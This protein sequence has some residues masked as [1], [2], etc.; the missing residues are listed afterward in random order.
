MLL[1]KNQ[2][3]EKELSI[4]LDSYEFK[5]PCMKSYLI[6]IFY[7]MVDLN[8][9]LANPFKEN[10]NKNISELISKNSIDRNDVKAIDQCLEKIISLNWR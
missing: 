6:S 9:A 3:L 8:L 10:F 1:K 7:T 5:N 2:H 4:L